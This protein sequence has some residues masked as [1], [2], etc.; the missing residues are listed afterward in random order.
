MGREKKD[1]L[2]LRGKIWWMN[3]TAGKKAYQ[4]STGTADKK[5]AEAVLAKV[6]TDLIE[7]KW[8]DKVAAMQ[9][10]FHEMRERFM[11]DHAPKVSASMQ[12]SYITS[13]KHL[14]SFFEGMTLFEIDTDIILRYQSAR[15]EENNSA[16]ATRNRELAALSCAFNQARLWKWTK[17]NPCELVKRE[18]EGNEDFGQ[19][20]PLD[21][22]EK[23]LQA[24]KGFCN[25]HLPAIVLT[26]LH[27]GFREAEVLTLHRNNLNFQERKISV[28]QKGN[29]LK[30]VPMTDTVNNL[31]L[32]KLKVPSMS[33]FI[34][35][36]RA[37]TPIDSSRL[38]REFKKAC[39][40]VGLEGF[41]FHDLRHTTG[42]RLAHAAHDIYSI[43][44]VLGHS[45]LKTTMRYAKHNIESLKK[46]VASLER[47]TA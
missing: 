18:K 13:F 30:V 38:R 22:D 14:S 45:Q 19:H 6:K 21:L 4:R 35:P 33:G 11:K 3:F 40:L 47:K 9:Y 17:E 2:Y 15:R 46:V 1:G 10:S 34:F 23:L 44:A 7:G 12:K 8:F 25:G 41:R 42:T 37:D 20:L 31:L 16:P 26:T 36:S 29:R 39:K 27:T 43:A 28:I 24:C 5:L 32:E